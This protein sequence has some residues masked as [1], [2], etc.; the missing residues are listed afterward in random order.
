MNALSLALSLEIAPSILACDF[1]R[2]GE[3]IK[4]AESLGAERLHIDVMDGVFVPNISIGQVVVECIRRITT[5]FLDVHLMIEKPHRYFADFKKAGADQVNFHVEEYGEPLPPRY[6]YPKRVETVNEEILKER[7]QEVKALG[8]KVCLVYNPATPLCAEKLFPL[9]DEILLMSVN[10]GFGGQKFIPDTL[11]KIQQL[12]K[13][14]P[15]NIKVDGGIN[16]ETIPP[17]LEA[18]ANVLVMGTSFFRNPQI[19]ELLSKLRNKHER[20]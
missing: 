2:L 13:I 9:I 6:Q 11:E 19:K 3:E 1:T 4:K 20:K 17:V 10:P 7:I 16:R 15:G 14:F 18:G 12:R 5:L 8:M